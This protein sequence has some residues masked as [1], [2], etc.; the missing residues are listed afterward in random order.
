[1]I[2]RVDYFVFVKGDENY[3]EVRRAKV[4]NCRANALGQTQ[5]KPKRDQ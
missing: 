3:R 1:M 4:S 5:R 2:V